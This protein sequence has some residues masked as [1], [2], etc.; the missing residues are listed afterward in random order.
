MMKINYFSIFLIYLKF[1]IT[2]VFNL[3][4]NSRRCHKH[5]VHLLMGA[6][7]LSHWYLFNGGFMKNLS[8][9]FMRNTRLTYLALAAV[10]VSHSGH[11]QAVDAALTIN[12]AVTAV[13]CYARIAAGSGNA[14]GGTGSTTANLT[15]PT[16]NLSTA[17]GTTLAA[18]AGATLATQKFTVGLASSVG[19]AAGCGAGTFNTAF[20]SPASG[21]TTVSGLTNRT[22]LANTAATGAASGVLIELAAFDN[23]TGNTQVSRISVI[24]TTISGVTFSGASNTSLQTTL[25][26]VSNTATQTFEARLVKTV[27]A[28]TQIGAGSIAGAVTVTHALF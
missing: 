24:P 14:G 20:T 11:A 8:K 7:S 12:G 1:N 18:A 26:A 25:D 3:M 27:A 10:A 9:N 28:G 2:I 19:G 5:R 23:A 13:S 6:A 22:F 21:I 15:I 16:I 4:I 17:A